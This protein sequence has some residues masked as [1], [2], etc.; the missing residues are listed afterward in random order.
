[1]GENAEVIPG[2]MHHESIS[3]MDMEIS[4]PGSGFGEDGMSVA[5]VEV[6]AGAK[7]MLIPQS[8]TDTESTTL[9]IGGFSDTSQSL[10]GLGDAGKKI[11]RKK[12]KKKHKHNRGDKK[13]KDR[14]DKEREVTA[15]SSESSGP[16]S[17]D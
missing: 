13:E 12:E 6:V 14:T 5:S 7:E 15:L 9:D 17:P 4:V 11:K 10:P 3:Q 2:I 16:P 1:M 8:V